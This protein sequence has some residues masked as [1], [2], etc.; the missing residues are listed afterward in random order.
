[1]WDLAMELLGKGPKV[2]YERCVQA[3]CGRNPAPSDPAAKRARVAELLARAGHS[4]RDGA[5]LL[6]AVDAWRRER[7]VPMKSVRALSEAMIAQYDRLVEANVLPHLPEPFRRVPRA[8]I[9]FLPIQDAWFS[10][11]MNYLGRARRSDGSPEYEATYE[12]NASLAISVPE[13]AQLVTHEV[14]PGHVTTFAFLQ[15]LYVR[16]EAGFEATVQTMNTRACG[17][18]EGIANN[19]ILM[20][21]GVREV[22]EL[23]EEDLQIGVLL[24]L[25]QDDAKN[26]SSYLTWKEGMPQAEV[27]AVLRRDYL[28]SEERANKLS[29]AWGRHPLLGRMYLPLYRAGTEFV[30][31]LRRRHPPAKVLPVLYGCQ[32]L[33]DMTTAAAA[34]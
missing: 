24:A 28:V 7:M 3:S 20:A 34:L 29:G 18:F 2:E 33:V 19:A 16:G 14:V 6:E 15:D 25:L 22:E 9:R 5:G 1:M 4:S 27:A 23:P 8:N 12:I 13:F 17:L 31:D 10:G 26:Q 11:S 21:Y 32:G 30:A